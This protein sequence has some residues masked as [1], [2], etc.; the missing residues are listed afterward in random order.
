MRSHLLAGGMEKSVTDRRRGWLRRSL[1]RLGLLTVVVGCAWGVHEVA[2]VGV[3]HVAE[4]SAVGF[5]HVAGPPLR[6]GAPPVPPP[7]GPLQTAQTGEP[8]PSSV[9][10]V[11]AD[12]PDV[13]RIATQLTVGLDGDL[14]VYQVAAY[15]LAGGRSV[16]HSSHQGAEYV[17]LAPLSPAPASSGLDSRRTSHGSAADLGPAAWAPPPARSQLTRRVR[18]TRRPSRSPRPRSRPA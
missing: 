2:A 13:A 3:A 17:P 18:A 16:A 15:W 10:D 9:P 14:S 4:M 12:E 1:L 11:T 6:D 5:A 7:A 8:A